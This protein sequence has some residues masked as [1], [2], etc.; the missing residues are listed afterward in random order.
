MRASGCV[1]DM[2]QQQQQH[3]TCGRSTSSNISLAVG[4]N[5]LR[6][7]MHKRNCVRVSTITKPHS[8]PEKADA[9]RPYARLRAALGIGRHPVASGASVRGSAS[10][11]DRVRR[12][13][14]DV[15]TCTERGRFN[16]Y[17]YMFVLVWAG[18]CC[19]SVL[20]S[21][22]EGLRFVFGVRVRSTLVIVFGFGA[23]RGGATALHLSP[24]TMKQ[25]RLYAT[26]GPNV[27]R[28]ATRI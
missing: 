10:R 12:P 25:L 16:M 5:P 6:F 28:A 23:P 20:R 13:C 17:M 24:L 15:L 2:T 3:T 11:P 21:P 8:V 7:G 14:N 18:L 27:C 26:F 4:R 1:S 9:Y 22:L 19:I